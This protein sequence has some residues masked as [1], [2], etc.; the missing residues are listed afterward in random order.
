MGRI[1]LVGLR[2]KVTRVPQLRNKE[3]SQRSTYLT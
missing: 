3:S 1:W 2:C